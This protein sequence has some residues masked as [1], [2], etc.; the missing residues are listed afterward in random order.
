MARKTIAN[1]QKV[2]M[3]TA[4]PGQRVVMVYNGIGK[5]LRTAVEAFDKDD[6]ARFEVISNS[7]QLAEK[8]IFELQLALDKEKGGEIA[9]NLDNLYSFWREHLSNANAEKDKKKVEE[10]LEM[11]DELTESWQEAERKTRN[12]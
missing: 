8:L 10:V 6:P 3:K 5:N 12:S 1:Y 9:E 2:Q 4:S 7:L 11:V